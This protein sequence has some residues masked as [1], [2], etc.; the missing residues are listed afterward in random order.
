[1]GANKAQRCGMTDPGPC[2]I[3]VVHWSSILFPTYTQASEP[4]TR[5]SILCFQ[6]D[7]LVFTELAVFLSLLL[8]LLCSVSTCTPGTTLLYCASKDRSSASLQHL[9]KSSLESFPH[10]FPRAVNCFI[11]SS[12]LN[13]LNCERV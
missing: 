9:I 8:L 6:C 13:T 5:T 7:S 2:H 10:S 1:M 3:L 12:T 11:Y 4:N